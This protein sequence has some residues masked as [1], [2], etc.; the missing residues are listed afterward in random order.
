MEVFHFEDHLAGLAIAL[1][2]AFFHFAP[3]HVA[4]EFLQSQILGRLGGDHLAVAQHGDRIGN[5]EK[6]LQLVGDVDAGD[7][8][9]LERLAGSPSAFRFRPR[10]RALVGSSRIRILAFSESAL[11]I[12][13]ICILPT[14]RLL[15]DSLGLNIQ[16]VFGQDLA[17]YRR[18]ACPS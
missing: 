2:E 1:G 15:D 4:D 16:V 5:A 14:P 7:A 18:R 8:M 6:F 3:D 10:L 17:G 11:A 12:S 13:V 9:L